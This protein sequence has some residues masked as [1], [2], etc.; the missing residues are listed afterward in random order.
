MNLHRLTE[1]TITVDMLPVFYKQ[2]DNLFYPAV[3][4]CSLQAFY[5]FLQ[6]ANLQCRPQ[7]LLKF[8][9]VWK[10]GEALF[11]V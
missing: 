6:E 3:R 7:R 10:L 8:I 2:R 1:M 4:R 9:L 5:F 11:T